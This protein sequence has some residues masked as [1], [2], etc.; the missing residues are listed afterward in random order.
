MVILLCT[1]DKET[2][3]QALGNYFKGVEVLLSRSDA[4]DCLEDY[5]SKETTRTVSTVI[6]KWS[7]NGLFRHDIDNCPFVGTNIS[8]YYYN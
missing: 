6:S 4:L 5:A 1:K 2:G 8:K 7:H 3:F